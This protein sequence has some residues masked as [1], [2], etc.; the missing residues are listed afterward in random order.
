MALKSIELGAA[1][2][3]SEILG[4]DA[5]ETIFYESYAANNFQIPKPLLQEAQFTKVLLEDF[6][7]R[8][9]SRLVSNPYIVLGENGEE[10]Y[11][12]MYIYVSEAVKTFLTELTDVD[13]LIQ[14]GFVPDK[15]TGLALIK[16]AMMAGEYAGLGAVSLLQE[17]CKKNK[18][19][20]KKS[21]K[22]K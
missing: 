17:A 15:K 13:R 8:L 5:P 7:A 12:N 6:L 18:K 4:K 10:T 1:L 22:N 21:K 9:Y 19:N 20:K 11:E 2:L 14:E 16:E 3:E